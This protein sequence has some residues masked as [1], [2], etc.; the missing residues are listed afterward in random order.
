M[1]KVSIVGKGLTRVYAPAPGKDWECWGLPSDEQFDLFDRLLEIH[2]SG[3][4]MFNKFDYRERLVKFGDRLWVRDPVKWLPE[5][6]TYPMADVR[7]LVGDYLASSVSY[8]AA[9]A[10]LEGC[11]E[12]SIAGCDFVVPGAERMYQRP[13]LEYL[14]GFARGRGIKVTVPQ[15]SPLMRCPI[16]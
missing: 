9:L 12:L 13:S 11:D 5:A 10:I 2:P 8:W 1:R 6:H 15:E 7:G 14:I 4:W 3:F 16:Y